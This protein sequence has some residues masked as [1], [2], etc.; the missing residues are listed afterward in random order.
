[1]S[2][3]GSTVI[4][5]ADDDA[6]DCFLVQEALK[7]LDGNFTLKMVKNGEELLYYLNRKGKYS[8]EKEY[9]HPSLVLLDLNMPRKNGSEALEE[10][11]NNKKHKGLPVVVF[12]TSSAH[13]DI[14]KMYLKGANSFITKPLTF[15]GMVD[16]LKNL[17]TYWFSTVKLPNE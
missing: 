11:R 4:L 12:S 2:F 7:E 9:P 8:D 16:T 5:V 17:N 6:D 14:E 15:E 10:I 1:M 3:Y 13:E